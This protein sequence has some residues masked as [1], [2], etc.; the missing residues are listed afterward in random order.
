MLLDRHF[1]STVVFAKAGRPEPPWWTPE[2]DSK[3]LESE[4]CPTGST[5]VFSRAQ[6][7]LL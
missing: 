3:H 4:S 1:R 6:W 2:F 5:L 7:L